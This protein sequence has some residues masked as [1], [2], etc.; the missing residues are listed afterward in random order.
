MQTQSQCHTVTVMG[1]LRWGG[2]GGGGGGLW[3]ICYFSKSVRIKYCRLLQ[4]VGG[5]LKVNCV[6]AVMCLSVFIASS[7]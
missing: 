6:L 7:S 2:G 4:I 3:L 1:D 5:A